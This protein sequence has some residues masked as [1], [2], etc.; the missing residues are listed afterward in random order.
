M[1]ITLIHEREF[2][3][4]VLNIYKIGLFDDTDFNN[5]LKD[6]PKNSNILYVHYLKEFNIT[7][8]QQ[9]LAK[10]KKNFVPRE[11]LGEDYYQGD[12]EKML[13]IINYSLGDKHYHRYKEEMKN[14][15]YWWEN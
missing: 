1:Y 9:I 4:Q 12:F 7:I 10:F 5:I 11:D 15:V 13:E 14:N 8:Y 6:V 3:N 2:K